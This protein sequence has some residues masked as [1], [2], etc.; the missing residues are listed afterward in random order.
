MKF[1][2]G[3]IITTC[4][5]IGGYI[6]FGGHIEVLWQPYEVA[7]IVGAAVGV[8]VLSNSIHVIKD[9]GTALIHVVNGKSLQR[10]DYLD[11]L[12]LLFTIFRE[13]KA[14]GIM[15]LENDIE[16]P[17]E[18]KL[19]KAHPRAMSRKRSINFLCDYLRL[20]SLGSENSH[21][22][23]VLIEQEIETL[24]H[25]M[26]RPVKALNT[27][28]EA[29][30]AFGIIAAVLGIIKAMGYVNQSTEV[31]GGM[32]GG[33]L[34]GTFL[35]VLLAYALVMPVAQLVAMRRD[36]TINYY[37]CMKAGLVAYLS[38]YPPQIAIEYARKVLFA[39]VQPT[40]DAV[41]KTTT[42]SVRAMAQAA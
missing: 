7:I 3:V 19:F 42:E 29:L 40:F 2:I 38:G 25:E 17:E 8:F 35:G 23:E 32:I 11:L 27:I 14:K 22:L 4:S 41:E 36:E 16:R 5:M 34:V 20:I 12:S 31:L 18:S 28:G 26:S 30:P 37:N 6:G 9:T 10:E 21:E 15:A 13:G 33:A 24:H 1:F 39:E